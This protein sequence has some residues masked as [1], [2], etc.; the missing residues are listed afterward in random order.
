MKRLSSY[1]D[2]QQMFPLN[3]KTLSDM[4]DEQEKI[5]QYSNKS[6][7]LVEETLL[8]SLMEEY[9]DLNNRLSF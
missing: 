6:H 2:W 9:I 1:E 5:A 8:V 3:L 4:M 7:K